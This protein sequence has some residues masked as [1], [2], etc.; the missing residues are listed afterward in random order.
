M[1]S[2]QQR[3]VN[4]N[5]RQAWESRVWRL[6]YLLTGSAEG[7]GHVVERVLMARQNL[8]TVT[9]PAR[10]DRLVA[11]HTR[12]RSGRSRAGRRRFSLGAYTAAANARRVLDSRMASAP[13]ITLSGSAKRL[14]ELVLALDHQPRLAWVLAHLEQVDEI[15]LAK[16][17]D[18]SKT[19]ARVHLSNAEK[20]LLEAAS[21]RGE[22]KAP[23][24]VIDHGLQSLREAIDAIDPGPYLEAARADIRERRVGRIA[25]AVIL[26]GA[27]VVAARIIYDLTRT[28]A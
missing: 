18:C 7:A 20:S 3:P 6:A 11:L 16:A 15:W 8:L 14:H 1:G 19:A 9:D 28:M 21:T 13:E 24:S 4:G 10:I 12:E 2:D 27:A 23:A 5:R 22:S 17:M 25:L 26:L